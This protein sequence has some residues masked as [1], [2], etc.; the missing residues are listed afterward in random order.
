LRRICNDFES[1]LVLDETNTC[2]GASGSGFWQHNSEADPDYLAFGK[3]TQVTGFFSKTE[4][5]VLGGYE[6]DLK[7]FEAIHNTVESDGL[8]DNAR[9]TSK[10]VSEM[11]SNVSGNGITG[12]RSSGTSVWVSTD[13]PA[14]AH[15]LVAHLRSH[16][17]LVQPNGS[18]V[19]ARPTLLFGDMQAKELTDALSS[20]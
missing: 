17:V 3:R 6:N 13:S 2:F 18:G 19:V 8:I 15:N 4:G 10:T 14:T 5:D 1:A 12:V 11:V 9:K 16:G 20:F 7:L